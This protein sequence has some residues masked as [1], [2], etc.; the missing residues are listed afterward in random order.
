MKKSAKK[1]LEDIETDMET[2]T[3]YILSQERENW[4]HPIWI[5]LIADSSGHYLLR[6]CL[7]C[8]KSIYHNKKLETPQDERILR[9]IWLLHV[10][11]MRC[12]PCI[13]CL[14]PQIGVCNMQDG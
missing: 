9:R 10:F 4:W 1:L 5:N 7:I 13:G 8:H 2:R 6:D 14:Q 3:T 12:I 11:K